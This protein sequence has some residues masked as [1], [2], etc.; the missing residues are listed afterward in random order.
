MWLEYFLDYPNNLKNPVIGRNISEIY[1]FQVT[2]HCVDL[3]ISHKREV[4]SEQ[5]CANPFSLWHFHMYDNSNFLWQK[6]LEME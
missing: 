3:E 1:L 5:N 6:K 2:T 4:I